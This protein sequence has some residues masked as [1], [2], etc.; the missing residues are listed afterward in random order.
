MGRL[1]DRVAIIT[2]STRGVG[3]ATAALFAAEGAKVV[4]NSRNAE[5]A[6]RTAEELGGEAVGIAADI[7]T[8][9]GCATLVDETL[10]R[11]GALDVLVNNAGTMTS[12]P[13]VDFPLDEWHRIMDIN[14]TGPFMLCQRA[15]RQMFAQGGGAIVNVA[16][17]SGITTPPLRLAYV[18]A[19]AGLIA[20]TKALAA[21]W[22]PTVRVNGMVPG[23]VQTE[24]LEQ[25]TAKGIFKP[26]AALTRT[27]YGRFGRPEELAHGVLFLASDEA[28]YIAGAMLPVDGAWLVSGQNR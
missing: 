1:Q 22:S 2:G 20:M 16:S 25:L 28:S 13:A 21:E 24:L 6:R 26:E 23:V 8:P 11:F 5:E 7:A 10:A 17:V 12:H 15:G 9:E 3:L 14:L 19:K 18:T 4:V 27:P